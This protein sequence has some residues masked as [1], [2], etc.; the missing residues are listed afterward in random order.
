MSSK[1][2][3]DSSQYRDA[4]PGAEARRRELLARRRAEL[5]A[6]PLELRRIYVRRAARCAAGAVAVTGALAVGM[7][8]HS[9][10]LRRAL[11]GLF[12]GRHPAV[13]SNLTVMT[14][15]GAA[16]AYFVVRALA[17]DRF[18]SCMIRTVRPSDDVFEDLERLELTPTRV[19]LSM[20]ERLRVPSMTLVISGVTALAPI[21]ALAAYS[22]A[23]LGAWNRPT[24][25]EENAWALGAPLLHTASLAI[26]A[27]WAWMVHL[28]R[29]QAVAATPPRLAGA[30]MAVAF[31]LFFAGA[32]MGGSGAR[33]WV[34][35]AAVAGVAAG[36][37][38]AR[39][40]VIGEDR[41]VRA[42]ASQNA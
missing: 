5:A 38:A 15:I 17:E 3:P 21:L 35:A 12:P 41:V 36:L 2:P 22:A 6:Q 20:V 27:S 33:L 11:E 28:R 37:V 16:L 4:R 18:T 9:P 19:A 23:A 7:A 1:A 25:F 13:V 42:A 40:A 10:L 14:A 31:F 8:A 34:W 32:A 24:V 29:R 26:L 30:A 39:A